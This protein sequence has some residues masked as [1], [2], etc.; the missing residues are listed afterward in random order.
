MR[1]RL[2]FFGSFFLGFFSVWISIIIY[3]L[4][5]SYASWRGVAV[6]WVTMDLRKG[7]LRPF[8]DVTTYDSVVR[9]KAHWTMLKQFFFSSPVCL[10]CMLFHFLS[11][12]SRAIIDT[13]IKFN[14]RLSNLSLSAFNENMRKEKEIHDLAM[15]QKARQSK[16]KEK[17]KKN[18]V[19]W[20][21]TQKFSIMN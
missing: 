3:E 14:F 20:R 6:D 1:N 16:A 21:R 7:H 2:C 19:R 12:H 13:M 18:Y 15:P 9:T 11:F 5:W 10:L 17:K 8:T 4:M